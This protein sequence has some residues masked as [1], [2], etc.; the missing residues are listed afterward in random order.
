MDNINDQIRNRI[1]S[2]IYSIYIYK[3]I[4]S[5]QSSHYFHQG[6]W[7]KRER[8]KTCCWKL[9]KISWQLQLQIYIPCL[10]F[11]SFVVNFFYG[12][13]FFS[14]IYPCLFSPPY[15]DLGC[16]KSLSSGFLPLSKTSLDSSDVPTSHS[17]S[18]LKQDFSWSIQAKMTQSVAALARIFVS[19][20]NRWGW[21]NF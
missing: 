10:F 1:T 14:M 16:K 7:R 3:S 17:L 15:H 6:T 19:S 20:S 12:L 2:C 13:N 8:I 9:L 11:G 4:Y 18:F 21:S 5:I